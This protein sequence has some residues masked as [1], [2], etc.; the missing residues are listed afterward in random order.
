MSLPRA[1]LATLC[2]FAL[3]LTGCSKS[4][5]GS[6]NAQFRI[7]NAFSEA[8]AVNAAVGGTVVAAGLGFQ[9]MTHYVSV[10]SGSQTLLVN[11]V[12]AVSPLVNTTISLG[13]ANYSYLLYGTSSLLGTTLAIDSFNDPGSGMF[14]VRVANAAA[15]VGPLDLY[16]TAPGADLTNTAPAVSNVAYGGITTFIALNTAPNFEIRFTPVGTKTV[17]FDTAPRI[18]PEHSGT[19]IV[20]Y[21]KGSGSLVNVALLNDDDSGTGA[22]LDNTLARYKVINASQVASPLNVFVDGSLQLSNIPFTGVSNYQQTSSGTHTITVQ[23]QAT[24]GAN[25]LTLT[26][27]LSSATDTSIPLVGPA[28][29][30]AGVILTDDNQPPAAGSA[31]VR[32]VNTS[33]D[34]ASVDVYVNFSKQ[35]SAL[36]QNTAS[37]YLNLTAAVVTGTSYEFDFNVAGTTTAVLKLPSVLMVAPHKYTVY[38]AGPSSSLQGIVTQDQ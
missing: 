31:G 30:L 38:L 1:L 9:G 4:G 6:G 21:S 37:S 22:I 36:A 15:G 23:A 12:G 24:P 20:A 28:G 8:T 11:V 17:I 14:S 13:G 25:L 16:L 26:P 35:V 19:T 18:F 32:F 5:G 29:A 27:T 10:P 7:F 34:I 33:A 3:V 2:A